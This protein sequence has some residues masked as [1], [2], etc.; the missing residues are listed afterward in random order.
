MLFAL[1]VFRDEPADAVHLIFVGHQGQALQMRAF[2][3]G[4]PLRFAIEFQPPELIALLF[5]GVGVRSARVSAVNVKL[6]V[7]NRSAEAG[8]EFGQIGELALH[9]GLG[10]G[11]GGFLGDGFRAL[12]RQCQRNVI[13][14]LGVVF[15][16]VLPGFG[17]HDFHA[18]GMHPRF[19][20]RR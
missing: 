10:F 14:N 9:V 5:E 15:A 4:F 8:D 16:F 20:G 19:S 11:D 13:A 1:G 18:D 3:D 17:F 6:A 2:D 12:N 7:R